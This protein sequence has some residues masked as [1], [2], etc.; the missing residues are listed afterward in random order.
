[1]PGTEDDPRQVLLP[2]SP[3]PAY[4]LQCEA[5]NKTLSAIDK[6]ILLKQLDIHEKICPTLKDISN[7]KRPTAKLVDEGELAGMKLSAKPNELDMVDWIRFKERWVR[8][9]AQQHPGRDLTT[10][11]LNLAENV[12]N[13]V[14]NEL[15]GVYEVDKII[16]A[17]EKVLVRRINI[18]EATTN[19]HSDLYNQKSDERTDTYVTRLR[20]AVVACQY[21][22]QRT[23]KC[24]ESMTFDFSDRMMRD[25]MLVGLYD[26]EIRLKVH[27]A[28]NDTSKMS[29]NSLIDLVKKFEGAKMSAQ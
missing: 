23:C 18:A 1:M 2:P 26:A 13:E 14:T 27:E 20:D 17:M 19:F 4:T 22:D 5:C 8:W 9:K 25:R 16:E 28:W 21:F 11:L 6:Q 15:G 12:R 10:S 24:S 3:P 29:M 7:E